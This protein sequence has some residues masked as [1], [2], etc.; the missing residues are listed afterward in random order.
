MLDQVI[1]G[2]ARWKVS[3]GAKRCFINWEFTNLSCRRP[4]LAPF[5]SYTERRDYG[6]GCHHRR[7]DE[8]GRGDRLARS[9]RNRD[10]VVAR[11]LVF[12]RILHAA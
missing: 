8:R 4:V 12:G 1:A 5:P 3:A 6:V 11:H 7:P 9:E 10:S 2:A